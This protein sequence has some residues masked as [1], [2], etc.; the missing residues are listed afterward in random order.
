MNRI[1]KNA[2]ETARLENRESK[3][4]ADKK[5]PKADGVVTK[6]ERKKLNHEENKTSKAIYKQKHY[7]QTSQH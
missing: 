3:I 5:E 2:K 1:C 4:Q 7:A 6:Q